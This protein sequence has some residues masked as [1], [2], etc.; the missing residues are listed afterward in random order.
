MNAFDL[1][2]AAISETIE[3]YKPFVMSSKISEHSIQIKVLEC[4]H[5]I[6]INELE[7]HISLKQGVISVN[8]HD[9]YSLQILK[10]SVLRLMASANPMMTVGFAISLGPLYSWTDT[11]LGRL[12]KSIIARD[13][14]AA[15]EFAVRHLGGPWPVA[16]RFRAK[17][18]N[19][20]SNL[21]SVSVVYA[22]KAIKGRWPQD[23]IGKKAETTI[24]NTSVY[25]HTILYAEL[26]GSRWVECE[27]RWYDHW[28][29]A[30]EYAKRVVKAPWPDDEIGRK[31]KHTLKSSG[32]HIY[33]EYLKFVEAHNANKNSN[34][35][36]SNTKNP[37]KGSGRINHR[38]KTKSG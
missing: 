8:I 20:I 28:G 37:D 23:E 38:R 11:R 14:W 29:W 19:N 35:P 7:I 36:R 24:L 26:I 1:I 15:C 9:P 34:T 2:E 10:R 30:L 4:T 25:S 17:A 31:A 32:T 27:S 13:S 21:S 18:E 16:D 6:I 5:T 3:P 12:I 22:M 33:A